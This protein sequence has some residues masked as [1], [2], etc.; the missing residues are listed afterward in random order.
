MAAF[1]SFKEKLH[2]LLDE[3]AAGGS[4]GGYSIDKATAVKRSCIA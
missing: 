4:D 3:F 1:T 2:V